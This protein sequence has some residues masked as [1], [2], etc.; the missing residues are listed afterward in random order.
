[1]TCRLLPLVY[2]TVPDVRPR[3]LQMKKEKLGVESMIQGELLNID[4]GVG[5][6]GDFGTSPATTD[7]Q[8]TAWQPNVANWFRLGCARTHGYALTPAS[9]CAAVHR[10]RERTRVRFR[11]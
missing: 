11:G 1:M 8:L 7:R 2:C 3:L 5:K 6:G 10:V 4:S 9:W